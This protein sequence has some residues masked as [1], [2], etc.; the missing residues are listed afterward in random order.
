VQNRGQRQNQI[1]RSGEC[2]IEWNTLEIGKR[3]LVLRGQ[4]YG[5]EIERARLLLQRE[6]TPGKSRRRL[7]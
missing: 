2:D 3:H 4:P 1:H 6:L 7:V 5:R